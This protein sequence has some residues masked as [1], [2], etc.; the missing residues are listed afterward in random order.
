MQ[1]W[2]AL[3][4]GIVQGLAEFLPISSSGH[5]AIL[6]RLF[7]L[8]PEGLLFFD[9][10]LHLGTLAAVCTVFYK[11]V[12]A[13]F[14]KPF[15][16]L[17]YLIAATIPAGI[18]GLLSSFTGVLENVILGGEYTGWFLAAFFTVTAAALILA[19]AVAKRRKT[20][21]PL[22]FKT[23]FTMGLAQAVAVLPGISRS[24]STIA[25]GTL[26]GGRAEEVSRFSFL[27]SVPIILSGFLLETVRGLTDANASFSAAFANNAGFG[28]CIVI[29]FVASALFGLLAIKI[30]YNAIKKANY[31]W[32]SLYLIILSVVCI[33]L[34]CTGC[35]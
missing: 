5:L 9:I 24:G 14:K 17:L 29:G 13:L 1:W 12:I 2:H 3:I 20:F 10:V 33:I 25:A 15:K 11:D 4:L 28:W 22:N 35:I 27:M 16:T 32:F 21:L 6:Q 19:E 26:A 8:D 30:T 18:V 31:K 34:Q 7:G 23:T